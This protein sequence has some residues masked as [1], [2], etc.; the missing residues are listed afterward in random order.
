MKAANT[1]DNSDRPDTRSPANFNTVQFHVHAKKRAE[2]QKLTE[3]ENYNLDL[4]FIQVVTAYNLNA[5]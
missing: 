4:I 1:P 5:C 3:S 2:R